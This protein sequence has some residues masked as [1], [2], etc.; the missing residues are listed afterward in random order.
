MNGWATNPVGL[1]DGV[2]QTSAV[3]GY[4]AADDIPYHWALASSFALCDHYSASAMSGT[5]PNRLCLMS[6]CI[7]DPSNPPFTP[8]DPWP[9]PATTIRTR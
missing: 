5:A 4:Y 7:Q 2:D 1:L 6:G 9:G 8:G 3:M